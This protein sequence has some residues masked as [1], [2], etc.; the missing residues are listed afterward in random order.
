MHTSSSFL[1]NFMAL[2]YL[3]E[4]VPQV[5]EFI[6]VGIQCSIAIIKCRLFSRQHLSSLQQRAKNWTV[7]SCSNCH[8][9]SHNKSVKKCH[10]AIEKAAKGKNCTLKHCSGRKRIVTPQEDGY[11][12][13]V[14]KRIR[15]ATPSQIIANPAIST[16]TRVSAKI[17]S[18]QLNKVYLYTRKP[19]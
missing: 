13:L 6:P 3:T 7:G 19:V 1:Q 18:F 8:H 11:V 12:S 9:Y 4:I 14:A 15:N 16:S 2:P 17:I 10:L 5:V